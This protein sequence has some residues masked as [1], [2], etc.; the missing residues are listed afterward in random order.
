[1]K[2]VMEYFV[3][4]FT[5]NNKSKSSK[6]CRKI[7]DVYDDYYV[8]KLRLLEEIDN[9]M[10]MGWDVSDTFLTKNDKTIYFRIIC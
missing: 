2:G 9:L 5:F 3:I 8:A 4:Q 7:I 10:S 1:M 6:R